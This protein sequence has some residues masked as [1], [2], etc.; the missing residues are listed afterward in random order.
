MS[1][2]YYEYEIIITTKEG[3][4]SSNLFRG[5]LGYNA[6]DSKDNDS[7]EAALSSVKSGRELLEKLNNLMGGEE[8]FTNA[9]WCSESEMEAEKKK[10]AIERITAYK[11]FSEVSHIL[12]KEYISWDDGEGPGFRFKLDSKNCAA[13]GTSKENRADKMNKSDWRNYYKFGLGISDVSG[14]FEGFE[15]ITAISGYRG[16]AERVLIP[17]YIEHHKVTSVRENTFKQLD[18]LEEIIIP[19]GVLGIGYRAFNSCPNLSKIIL[20]KSLV[21]IHPD[22]LIKCPQAVLLLPEG[23][24][25]I[26][27]AQKNKIQ[28]EIYQDVPYDYIDEMNAFLNAKKKRAAP[29]KV[30]KESVPV[31]EQKQKEKTEY[32]P[33]KAEDFVIKSG[34]LKKYVGKGGDVDLSVAAKTITEIGRSAFENCK[35][36]RSVKISSGVKKIGNCAFAGCKEL[37]SVIF[38]DEL[39]EIGYLAF[40]CCRTLEK[41]EFPESLK[42]IDSGAF[43]YCTALTS[44]TVPHNCEEVGGEQFKGCSNLV[45]AVFKSGDTRLGYSSF[46]G[47]KKVTVYAPPSGDIEATAKYDN[48]PFESI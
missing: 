36:I 12:I 47:C 11:D 27:C 26:S 30:Q 8:F 44:I 48:I 34:V 43:S 32:P 28:Y 33:C 3:R 37:R 40:N 7:L 23:S 4:K 5:R 15:K 35:G 1:S 42:R 19:E 25:A 10:K 16:G 9:Q 38:N 18:F 21:S 41:V 29:S 6:L 45:S 31:K 17:R 2:P 20:P 22:F 13:I 39:E 24:I 14:D 46:W